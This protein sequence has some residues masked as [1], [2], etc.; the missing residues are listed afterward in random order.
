MDSQSQ[1]AHDPTSLTPRTKI[2]VVVTLGLL[3]V[4]FIL[5]ITQILAPFLWALLAAYLLTPVVNYLNIDGKLPRLW[6]VILI[7][8]SV[9]LLLLA[10][11]RFLFPRLVEQGSLFVEDIPRLEV[12]LIAL[13]GPRPMG[14]D[15][16]AL[17][18]QLIRTAGTSTS[19]AR[20]A[21]HL[22]V[23]AVETVVKLFLFLVT[24]FY[25]LMDAPRLKEA[26][27]NALPPAFRPE[28]TALG[29]QIN[30]TWQQYIRGELLLFA[31]MATVTTIGLTILAVPGA[32]FLGLVSGVLELLPLVGPITAGAL[33]VSVAY[34]SGTNP[35]G[36]SQLVY[37]GIVAILY[38]FLRQTED[39]FVIPHVLGRAVRLHPLVVLFALAA[40]GVTAGLYGLLVAVPIAASVKA[41]ATYL[42]AK[43]LDLPVEFEP[44]RTIRGG[45]IEISVQTPSTQESNPAEGARAP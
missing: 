34:F 42:Y 20:T 6:S 12:S 39:Y 8:A 28:L 16:A 2:L 25:L 38:F 11:S 19:N 1:Q 5:H 18:D 41:I 37:G 32:I 45:I 43:L 17:V 30:I 21:G 3:I 27:C 10:G 36:W 31:L 23:N 7:Y 33:A 22:I 35:F 44:V 9:G 15:V 14:I 40:G 29:R 4:A 26:I 24:T 13:V